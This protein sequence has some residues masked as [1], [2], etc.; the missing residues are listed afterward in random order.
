MRPREGR[1]SG[2]APHEPRM[3]MVMVQAD[4]WDGSARLAPRANHLGQPGAALVQDFGRPSDGPD[5]LGLST[6]PASGA[7]T[8]PAPVKRGRG[9]PCGS[10][11][12]RPA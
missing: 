10:R 1:S 8:S 9:R 5:A 2:A 3:A 11:N 12:Q 6:P 7:L 4:E